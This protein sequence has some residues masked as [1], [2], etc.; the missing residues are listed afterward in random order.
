MSGL[1]GREPHPLACPRCSRFDC[2]CPPEL[3]LLWRVGADEDF[4]TM[5][6]LDKE[7]RC[8]EEED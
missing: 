8:L 2:E 5:I 7:R 1:W 6:E 4:S 3:R